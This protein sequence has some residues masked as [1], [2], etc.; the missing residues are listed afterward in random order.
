MTGIGSLDDP[1]LDPPAPTR[2]RQRGLATA[3]PALFLVLVFLGPAR[4]DGGFTASSW[5]AATVAVSAVL[6]ATVLSREIRISRFE[7]LASGPFVLLAGWTA[8]SLSWTASVPLTVNELERALLVLVALAAGVVAGRGEARSAAVAAF[9]ATAVVLAGWS[10]F[11][12]VDAPVGYANSLAIVCAA[13]IVLT[14]GWA[15][16]SGPRWS[17]AAVPAVFVLGIALL[18]TDSRAAWPALIAGAAIVVGLRCSRPAFVTFGVLGLSVGAVGLLALHESAQRTAYWRAALEETARHP[19]LGSGAGT[20]RQVWLEHRH[21]DLA[22]LNAHSLFLETLSELGPVGLGLLVVGLLVPLVAAVRA[23]RDPLVRAAAGA[24]AAILVHLA[25]DWDWQ[26]TVVLLGLL[27]LGGFLLAAVGD[28][29][30]EPTRVLRVPRATAAVTL[31]AVGCVGAWL[32]AGGHFATRAADELRAAEWTAALSDARRA[33]T[34]Q[35]WSADAWRLRGE[36]ERSNGRPDQGIESFRR[37]IRLDSSDVELWRAL[38]RVAT[39][40][41]LRLARSRIAQLDPRAGVAGG[42]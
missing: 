7:L 28:G 37:G 31:V 1:R 8:L 40:N 24:Y 21:A 34:L 20:W 16:A 5:G 23:R 6:L 14:G 39:G 10:L 15:L 33:V 2:P 18:R 26:I 4:L 32:W 27:F 29:E 42:P 13:G 30:S 9:L 12:G 22:A 41:E 35:P 17:R 11:V 19:L 38:E 3:L 36:A 25:V